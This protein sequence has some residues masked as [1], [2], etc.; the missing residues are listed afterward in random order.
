MLQILNRRCFPLLSLFIISLM[1]YACNSDNN[2][3]NEMKSL[4]TNSENENIEA[5]II[6]P[7]KTVDGTVYGVKG[8]DNSSSTSQDMI[9]LHY[10]RT[11]ELNQINAIL[12]YSGLP[13]NF[14]VFGAN[15]DNAV[16]TIIDNQRYILYD[17][18]LFAFTDEYSQS[19][20]SSM[21][22][23]AHEI[24]HHLSGHT[25][26][27]KGSN[28]NDELEADKFSGF[29]LYKMGATLEQSLAAME[30]LGSTHESSTHPAR[31]RR[32]R[33]IENGWN[34]AN[35]T[36]YNAAI[37]PPPPNINDFSGGLAEFNTE[38]LLDESSYLEL[39]S[40]NGY[41]SWVSDKWEGIITEQNNS[42]YLIYV[43]KV[44]NQDHNGY[45]NFTREKID[46]S[47]YDPWNAREPIG[48]AGLSWLS[49]ILVPGRRIQFA[50]I[51]EGTAPSRAFAYIKYLPTD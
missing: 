23:L 13:S 1:Q 19:F 14:K 35:E 28:P 18:K 4:N 33:A 26:E 21:S 36:R 12:K 41:G 7:T 40:K 17:P 6:E 43:T 46:I 9:T 20:W 42:I 24:G 22:I 47:L 3:E 15:I 39:R 25:I 30:L 31:D 16:A 37:P 5:R 11:R 32:L 50:F 44:G 2:N 45:E 34:E 29:V 10:P 51:E 48:R 27:S 49:A 38:N 8:C